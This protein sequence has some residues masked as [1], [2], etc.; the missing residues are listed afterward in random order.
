MAVVLNILSRF[1]DRGVR[2]A[3]A[4][5]AKLGSGARGFAG[6]TA[7][8]M[9]R[10]GA[11]LDRAGAKAQTAGRRMS[12]GVTLP[13]VAAGAASVKLAVDFDS[14]MS[15]IGS[16]VGVSEKQLAGYRTNVL[17]MSRELPQAP[18]E[19]AEAL[20]FITSAGVKGKGALEVLNASA[21][22][23][24]A[25]L[26]ETKTVADAA[27]SAINA[28]GIKNL[29]ASDATDVLV[30]TVREGKMEPSELAGALGKVIPVASSMGVSFDQV[31]AAIAGMTRTGMNARE[32][33]TALRAMLAQI[34]KPTAQTSDGLKAVG[35]SVKEVQES[36]R[37]KGLLPTLQLLNDKFDGNANK[38]AKVFG[39][40]RGLTGV[41][42]LMGPNAAKNATIF[43]KLAKAGGDTAA[44][45]K[46]AEETDPTVRFG[47]MKSSIQAS[48]IT[49]GESLLPAVQQAAEAIAK[50]ADRFGALSPKT[51]GVIVKVALAAAAMGPLVWIL[52]SF[53]RAAGGALKFAGNL[54]IAFGKNAKS[55]PAYARAIAAPIKALGSLAKTIGQAIAAL[56]RQGAAMAVS[57]AKTVASTAATVAS[58]VAILA[59]SAATKAWA[60]V[61]W[62]LNAAMSANPI[63]LVVIAIAA[64]VAAFVIAWKKSETFRKIV[65]GAWTAIKTATVRVFGAIVAFFKTWGPRILTVLAG[66]IGLVAKYII[67]H[68]QAIKQGA[69]NAFGAVISFARS[70]PGRIKSAVGNLGRTLYSA[71]G[72]LLRGIWNGMSSIAGWLKSKITGFFSSLLPGWAKKALGISSP[73]KV[74][75]EIGKYAGQG[76]AAGM[77]STRGLVAD[78]AGRLAGA[79]AGGTDRTFG[80][81]A[82]AGGA[83]RSTVL[84]VQP[85]AVT[86]SIG[87]DAGTGK[88]TQ[89]TIDA[90]IDRGFRRLAA[91]L[92]RR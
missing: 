60:A 12:L 65:L 34:L 48:A 2:R 36:L 37:G 44:A 66:P 53:M 4:S 7:A 43:E 87:A 32:A 24:A 27:T 23:A 45:F 9:V 1:D 20:F 91:E 49:L 39:N 81:P 82:F 10:A 69:V 17:A 8:D 90:A 83:G 88:T 26:G 79:A 30:A 25:G 85:G 70:I 19:L 3:Q 35:L 5:L 59:V 75:A 52:G 77:D 38:A 72:D 40:V 31:G 15:K 50:L 78:A 67:Q 63:G 76:L 84:N 51:Q 14:S 74:F 73:S 58:R 71:G 22:A 62:L 18:K 42:S 68:W 28:Y 16:L 47:K 21:K 13:I 61:Q 89:A 11:A 86:I 33:S 57:A 56:A 46:R 80:A 6:S 64:L 54:G 92:S 55:A 29:S 41:L